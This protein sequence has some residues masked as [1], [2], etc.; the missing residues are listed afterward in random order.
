[1]WVWLVLSAF[2]PAAVWGYPIISGTP[3]PGRLLR[4]GPLQLFSTI[5][6]NYGGVGTRR[7]MCMWVWLVLSAFPPATVWGYPIISG[8]PWPGRLLRRGP[9]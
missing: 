3:W 8:T 4:R 6:S 9:L 7:I 2:P 1:M 5:L